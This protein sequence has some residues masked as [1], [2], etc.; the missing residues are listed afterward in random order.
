MKKTNYYRLAATLGPRSNHR[1]LTKRDV[2]NVN[3]VK[4]CRLISSPPEPLSLRLSSTLL[5]GLTRIYGEQCMIQFQEAQNVVHKHQKQAFETQSSSPSKKVSFNNT[6]NFNSTRANQASIT[7]D[8]NP[9]STNTTSLD[10]LPSNDF[11]TKTLD[12]L[13]DSV[14][15][16]GQD[17]LTVAVETLSPEQHHLK[18]I[19][20]LTPELARRATLGSASG[21]SGKSSDIDLLR[22]SILNNTTPITPPFP[23][24]IDGS[25]FSTPSDRSFMEDYNNPNNSNTLRSGPGS[26]A[27]LLSAPGFM[28]RTTDDLD[29]HTDAVD[30]LTTTTTSPLLHRT[31][32]KPKQR[33][34]IFDEERIIL[35][36]EEL[37]FSSNIEEEPY[38]LMEM[39]SLKES[40]LGQE[41][42]DL[43][44]KT[45]PKP[46]K[47]GGI[48][49]DDL[50]YTNDENKKITN[51]NNDDVVVCD[52][53]DDIFVAGYNEE[54]P[55][56][57]NGYDEA[58]S[59]NDD[60]DL[61]KPT[62]DM[63]KTNNTPFDTLV[64]GVGYGR[65]G[66]VSTFSWVLAELTKGR[67]RCSTWEQRIYISK[68]L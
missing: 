33:R 53:D 7:L 58:F 14:M 13:L 68:Q 61:R 49:R 3:V 50:R 52:D 32:R 2:N 10:N 35:E 40:L 63:I 59:R 5:V 19:S 55:F 24:A 37:L 27:S 64:E 44:L 26:I 51:N 66:A 62:Y 38:A 45:V 30:H 60:N 11:T 15:I 36:K 12:E 8:L 4:S 34:R 54:Q 31:K 16:K 17:H 22:Q 42:Y 23:G 9:P 39:H 6:S 67:I 25:P 48:H 56:A 21:L 20:S 28:D 1:K 46:R 41:D 57:F 65:R 47:R 43:L 29:D 18:N